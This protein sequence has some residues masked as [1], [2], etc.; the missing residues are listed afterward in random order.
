MYKHLTQKTITFFLIIIIIIIIIIDTYLT[1]KTK[2]K[3]I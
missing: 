3:S 2:I 1:R